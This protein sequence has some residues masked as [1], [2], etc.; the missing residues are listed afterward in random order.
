MIDNELIFKI[1]LKKIGVL[2]RLA[3]IIVI[4]KIKS[5]FSYFP[6]VWMF[7]SRTSKNII[8]KLQEISLKIVTND[9]SKLMNCKQ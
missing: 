7:C 9:C 8:H 5:Q 3:K 2:S 1:H 4:T 6:L